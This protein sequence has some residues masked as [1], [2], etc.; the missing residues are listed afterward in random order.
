MQ[1]RVIDGLLNYGYDRLAKRL[2]EKW[3][4]CNIKVFKETGFLWEKY[5]VVRGR[6]GV[7]DRYPTQPGFGWTN[8]TFIILLNIYND[9]K[10]R[11]G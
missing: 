5:D 7:P 10:S 6:V 9:L 1:I 3:L 4:W 8:A 11:E 2:I